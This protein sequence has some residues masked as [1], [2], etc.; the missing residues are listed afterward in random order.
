MNHSSSVKNAAICASLLL[1]A[2]TQE[3]FDDPICKPSQNLTGVSQ[4]EAFAFGYFPAEFAEPNRDCGYPVGPLPIIS[5]IESVWY[6]QHWRAAG[7]PS[8][9]EL[10]S[11]DDPPSFAMRFSYIPT[12][13]PPV[14]IRIQPSEDGL[15][16]IV[17]EMTAAGG[18]G[19]GTI[20]RSKEVSLTTEQVSGLK[21]LLDEQALFQEPTT[22][23]K[24]GFDG[25]QWIFEKVDED[26]YK[27]V[28]RWSPREGAAHSLGIYLM[29]LSGWDFGAE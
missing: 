29:E 4:E 8:L 1:A 18:Y 26:G 7:E 2:C 12:F 6:L 25:S 13:Y 10:A 3:Q 5:E 15:K 17:K 14:F 22:I 24:L 28:S 20:S 16:L 11:C 27:M 19:T 21:R 23:C 9:Y